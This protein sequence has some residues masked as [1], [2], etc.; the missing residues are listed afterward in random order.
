M[1]DAVSTA[2]I[3][4]FVPVN[5][6]SPDNLKELSR[7]ARRMSLETGRYLFRDGNLPDARLFLLDGA[8]ELV[9]EDGATRTVEAGSREAAGSL[10][11]VGRRLRAARAR[12]ASTVIAVDR[13]LLDLMVTWDQTGGYQVEDLSEGPASSPDDW[14]TRLLQT[15]CFRR[16]PPANIQAIFM[17]MEPVQFNVGDVVI[18]QGDGGDYFY[19]IRDGRCLVT[20]A[21]RAKPEGVRLAELGPGDSFGEEALI[22]DKERNATVTMLAGG[23]LMRMSKEDFNALLNEP[24]LQWVGYEEAAGIVAGGGR[25]IDVRLPGEYETGHIESAENL[26]LFVLRMKAQRLDADTTYVV[27]CD[28]GRRSSAASFLL[29]ERGLDVRVLRDGL[30]A[31]PGDQLTPGA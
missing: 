27:Y 14:M 5:A 21:T 1:A 20:R 8:V 17:R 4:R 16:I 7:K 18:R 6:L 22:S 19:I 15:E 28:S 3:A 11:A 24:L 9:A 31:I 2:E 10:E 29:S 30:A 25:W 12:K 26:P 13:D 23:T